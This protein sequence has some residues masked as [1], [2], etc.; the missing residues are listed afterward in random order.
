MLIDIIILFLFF[1]TFLKINLY[2]FLFI[3]ITFLV[4]KFKKLNWLYFIELIALIIVFKNPIPILLYYLYEKTRKKDVEIY[5]FLSYLV[6]SSF[7]YDFPKTIILSSIMILLMSFKYKKFAY[8]FLIPLLFIPTLLTPY[9]TIS[10]YKTNEQVVDA[11]NVIDNNNNEIDISNETESQ[12]A[13]Q[14]SSENN[15]SLVSSK[16]EYNKYENLLFILL[17]FVGL[18]SVYILLKF[19]VKL[20]VKMTLF[21]IAIISYSYLLLLV[22]YPKLAKDYYSKVPQISFEGQISEDINSDYNMPLEV[23]T[24]LDNDKLK[25]KMYKLVDFVKIGTIVVIGAFLVLLVIMVNILKDMNKNAKNVNKELKQNVWK[26]DDTFETILN[27]EDKDLLRR[28]YVF[29]RAKIFPEYFYLTP[30]EL[31]D[32]IKDSELSYITDLFVKSEYGKLKVKYDSYELKKLLKI[33][34][35]KYKPEII[36]S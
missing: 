24:K 17:F 25:V 30:Y 20:T 33:I 8:L 23:A 26:T 4:F 6:A 14:Q 1:L 29:I 7:F 31:E 11:D 28:I 27:L 12:P 15:I 3:G 22:M 16:V 32:K 35:E 18:L 36:V 5:S 34:V 19:K 10:E 2:T 21:I 13:Y 9:H